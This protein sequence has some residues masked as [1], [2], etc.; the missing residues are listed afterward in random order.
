[1][2]WC[3]ITHAP[4]LI[5]HHSCS[6]TNATSLILHPSCLLTHSPSLT[7]HHSCAIS[8]API[9]QRCPITHAP[10]L[11]PHHSCPLTHAPSLMP[12]HSYPI[13]H[14]R[15]THARVIHAPSLMTLTHAHHSCA[16][17]SAMPLNH[18][19]QFIIHVL[20]PCLHCLILQKLSSEPSSC[21]INCFTPL[22]TF[23][24]LLQSFITLRLICDRLRSSVNKSFT[25]HIIHYNSYSLGIFITSQISVDLRR[26][27]SFL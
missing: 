8:R 1:M 19:S 18:R 16:N 11:N 17:T 25:W 26:N 9:H 27:G 6:I 7:S 20:L 5:P 24:F 15:V 3:P 10:S 12:H 2:Q 23:L 21:V 4:S 14:A 22:K 13:T